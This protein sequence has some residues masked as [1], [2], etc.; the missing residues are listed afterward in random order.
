[1]GS[2]F[3]VCLGVGG[4]GGGGA[5]QHGSRFQGG[6]AFGFLGSAVVFEGWTVMLHCFSFIQGLES[7]VSEN[8]SAT[9]ACWGDTPWLRTYV[10]RLGALKALGSRNLESPTHRQ[11][12]DRGSKIV[13]GGALSKAS[14]SLN[15]KP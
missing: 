1:M 6:W 9:A 7:Q 8:Y 11:V 10:A 5:K 3:R 2:A 15:P 14:A 13:W 4:G 12:L